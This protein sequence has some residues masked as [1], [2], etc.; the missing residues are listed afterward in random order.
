MSNFS[1]F[2]ALGFTI[3]FHKIEP[4]PEPSESRD[5]DRRAF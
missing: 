3:T 2:L 4:E 5:S 1:P